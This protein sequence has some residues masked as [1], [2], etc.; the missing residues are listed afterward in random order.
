MRRQRGGRSAAP[1]LHSERFF[2]GIPVA[3]VVDD[4]AIE[5]FGFLPGRPAQQ[6]AAAEIH[7]RRRR[8]RLHLGNLCGKLIDYP[9][10]HEDAVGTPKRKIAADRGVSGA[11]QKRAV[12]EIRFR[13]AFHPFEAEK[14]SVE[15]ERL[16][17]RPYSLDD[18]EPF[19]GIGIPF[20][21]FAD[22][23]TEHRV[24]IHVPAGNHVQTEPALPDM[25]GG[26]HLVRRKYGIH[27]RNVNCPENGD[28]FGFRQCPRRPGQ[29]FEVYAGRVDLAAIP[30][31]PRH[32]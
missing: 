19:L 14:L 13:G 12:A 26:D 24:F 29:R 8:G 18:R 16:V 22:T 17:L 9:R 15:I 28:V 3:V 7:A 20:V 30:A 6:V 23:D 1:R 25:V 31:P 4:V 21:M 2:H 27:Q 10:P 32:G 5:L 11:D